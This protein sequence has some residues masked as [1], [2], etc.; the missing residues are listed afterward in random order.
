MLRKPLCS[1]MCCLPMLF[2]TNVASAISECQDHLLEIWT[3]AGGE[4]LLVFNTVPP[5][6][7]YGPASA[8]DVA[9]KNAIAV[10][11]SAFAMNSPVTIRYQADGVPCSS[12]PSRSDFA[13]IWIQR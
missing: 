9:Q 10:A 2:L 6:Y 5:V 12:G 11:M 1:I 4:I 3:G 13:G 7:V 8:T